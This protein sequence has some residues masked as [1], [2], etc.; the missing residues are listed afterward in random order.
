NRIF[1][2]TTKV[3]INIGINTYFIV[4][5]TFVERLRYLQLKAY[6]KF[7]LNYITLY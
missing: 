6:T 4:N 5:N 3:L 2:S 7:K 1:I